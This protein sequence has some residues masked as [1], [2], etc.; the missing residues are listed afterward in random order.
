MNLKTLFPLFSPVRKGFFAFLSST[1][2]YL[3]I[4]GFTTRKVK[5]GDLWRFFAFR[6]LPRVYCLLNQFIR[7]RQHVRRNRQADLLGRL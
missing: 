5:S 7:P 2:S 1:G 4:V 6:L 3:I